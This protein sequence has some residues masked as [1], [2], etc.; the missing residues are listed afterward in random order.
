M[1]SFGPGRFAA[2]LKRVKTRKYVSGKEK[3]RSSKSQVVIC[4]AEGNPCFPAEKA[5]LGSRRDTG[6]KPV[7]D[8]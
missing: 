6:P 5:A 1:A 3:S 4:L 2:C 8:S 7:D